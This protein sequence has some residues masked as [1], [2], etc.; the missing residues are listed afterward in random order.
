MSATNDAPL[1]LDFREQVARIDRALAEID[2]SREETR[3]LSREAEPR[4]EALIARSLRDRAEAKS[5]ESRIEALLA[6]AAR[7]RAQAHANWPGTITAIGAVLAGLGAIL[8]AL[9]AGHVI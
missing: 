3:R 2:L 5:A 6:Q 8:A 1:G 4:I 9:F 7:D